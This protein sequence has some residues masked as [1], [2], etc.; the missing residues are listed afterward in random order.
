[1]V[2]D[3]NWPEVDDDR[4]MDR[5]QAIRG[6]VDGRL[7]IEALEHALWYGEPK[8][9]VLNRHS[10]LDLRMAGLI[11]RKADDIQYFMGTEVRIQKFRAGVSEYKCWDTVLA[12]D[13]EILCLVKQGRFEIDE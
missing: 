7:V 3:V 10:Y 13:G 5:R 1:M 4:V 2:S 6:K 12:E 11:D 9:I 8:Y